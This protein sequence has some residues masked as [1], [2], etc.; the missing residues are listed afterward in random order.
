MK[1]NIDYTRKHAFV[2]S[3]DK[4]DE[5][6]NHKSTDALK[7]IDEVTKKFEKESN[8]TDKTRYNTEITYTKDYSKIVSNDI[9][10]YIYSMYGWIEGMK[11]KIQELC[12]IIE[13]NSDEIDYKN[14]YDLFVVMQGKC[15]DIQNIIEDI[16]SSIDN[17]I[18]PILPYKKLRYIVKSL[19]IEKDGNIR[20]IK[21]RDGRCNTKHLIKEEFIVV[22]IKD[23]PNYNNDSTEAMIYTYKFEN[24]DLWIEY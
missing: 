11:E 1:E 19:V 7:K 23:F 17:N 10:K 20:I 15:V 4:V 8:I 12:I 2:V 18:K 9:V 13:N 3:E 24:K 6:I 22:N 5:F 14:I 21:S 16:D